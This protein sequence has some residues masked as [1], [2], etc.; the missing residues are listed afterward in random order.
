M[1]WLSI[2]R[3]RYHYTSFNKLTS[4]L[5]VGFTKSDLGRTTKCDPNHI[6]DSAGAKLELNMNISSSKGQFVDQ[7]LML[8]CSFRCD[9]ISDSHCYEFGH[10]LLRYLS[11]T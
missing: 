1:G 4:A 6:S 9:Q 3:Y 2:S 8:S 10:T 11:L 5:V 7:M